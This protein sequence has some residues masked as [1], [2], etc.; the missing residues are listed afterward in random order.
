MRS[1]W[2]NKIRILGY[3]LSKNNL[4]GLIIC[5]TF[6]LSSCDH[7]ENGS[8]KISGK[9]HSYDIP[10]MLI[11]GEHDSS[12]I[13]DGKFEGDIDSVVSLKIPYTHI[14]FDDGDQKSFLLLIYTDKDYENEVGLK[15]FAKKMVD[16]SVRIDDANNKLIEYKSESSLSYM[17]Y[18]ATFDPKQSE[19]DLDGDDFFVSIQKSESYEIDGVKIEPK[20]LCIMHSMYDGFALEMSLTGKACSINRLEEVNSLMK[21]LLIEWRE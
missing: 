8:V 11:K 18:I 2:S 9:S 10:E 14:S 12:I 6:A 16:K 1:Y 15:S 5:I 19:G 20:E 13:F 21:N 17:S 4:L 3:I 7:S